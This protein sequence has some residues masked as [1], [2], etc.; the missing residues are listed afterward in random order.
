MNVTT[1]PVLQLDVS[2]EPTSIISA[3][4]AIRLIV[5]GAADPVIDRDRELRPGFKL[6]SVIRL[7]RYH[8]VPHRNK[9]LVGRKNIYARDGHVCQYCYQKFSPS[10]LTLDH[11]LPSSRGG[12][13]TWQNLVTACGR[14]NRK[15]ADRTPE[16]AGMTLLNRP[17]AVNIFTARYLLRSLGQQEAEWRKYLYFE[18]T[19]PQE[20]AA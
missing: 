20:N 18:N 11:V 14:C 4:D 8:Y 12:Q 2:Y 15:K 5:K 6:P 13:D 9:G 10:E 1:T 7:N 3:R 17:R 16:E 19:T